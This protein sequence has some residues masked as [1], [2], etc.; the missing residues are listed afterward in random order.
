MKT[1]V[2]NKL[3]EFTGLTPININLIVE[4]SNL[5][6]AKLNN[7]LEKISIYFNNKIIDTEKLEILLN[8]RSNEDFNKLKDAA[9]LGEKNETN[10]LLSDT[11]IDPDKNILYL[12]VINQRLLRL[13]EISNAKIENIDSR[14]NSLKPPIFWKDKTNFISQAKKWP[15]KKIKKI[16]KKTYELEK[17]IKSNSYINKNILIKKLVIDICDKAN[18]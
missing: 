13:S 17:Q 7:E 18:S 12:N 1:I 11:L 10:K 16:L 8:A 6:R 5:D 4:N 9:L 14:V 2:Q 3:R 15:G